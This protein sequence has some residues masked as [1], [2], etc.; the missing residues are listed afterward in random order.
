VGTH[1]VANSWRSLAPKLTGAN[2]AHGLQVETQPG[3]GV[4]ETVVDVKPD[5]LVATISQEV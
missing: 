5:T 4:F 2:A 1:Y 3:G